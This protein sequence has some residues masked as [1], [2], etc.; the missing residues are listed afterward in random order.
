MTMNESNLQKAAEAGAEAKQTLAQLRL[1]Q[2]VDVIYEPRPAPHVVPAGERDKLYDFAARTLGNTPVRYLEFGVAGGKSMRMMTERFNH[3][4][5]RFFGFDCFEGIPEAWQDKPAGTFT[6]HGVLPAMTDKRVTLIKGYFQDTLPGF[7]STSQFGPANPV[8]VH[9][10]ADL[11][12]ST[13]FILSTLWP[14][15]PE[16][17]FLFDEFMSDEVIALHDF[18][19]AYPVEIEFLCRTD[20]R[21]PPQIFG[22]LK[23]CILAEKLATPESRA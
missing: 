3:P 6:M 8:L 12:S 18:S 19:R 16:Y 2:A 7:I 21:F 17:Y 22:R 14:C 5:A 1:K 11:Y 15:I 20:R 9:Y 23:R 13:L 10:D 4:D